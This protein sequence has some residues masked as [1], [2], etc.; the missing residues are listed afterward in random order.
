MYTLNII[1][2]LSFCLFLSGIVKQYA[3]ILKFYKSMDDKNPTV[4][5]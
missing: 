5:C 2:T 4:G 3:E 1:N